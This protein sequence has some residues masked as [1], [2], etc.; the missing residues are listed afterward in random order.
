MKFNIDNRTKFRTRHLRSFVT[1]A[2]RVACEGSGPARSRQHAGIYHTIYIKFARSNHRGKAGVTG[3]AYV[4]SCRA[5][6]GIGDEVHK[7]ELARVI[8]HEIAHTIGL[9]HDEM[10]GGPLM[11]LDDERER[12]VYGWADALPLDK[13]QPKPKP[14]GDE[15]RELKLRRIETRLKS[16]RTKQKRAET[17]IKKLTSQQRRL[18]RQGD[19]P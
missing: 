17:A 2:Y 8:A 18:V 15:R 3:H 12:R 6:V 7:R 5:H 13:V 11:H 10:A 9:R 4:N 1:R 14:Q 16:W 19:T